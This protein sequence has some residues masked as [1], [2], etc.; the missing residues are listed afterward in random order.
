MQASSGEAKLSSEGL[1]AAQTP[2]GGRGLP[3]EQLWGWMAQ[4]TGASAP[5]PACS[6]S[7]T[8]PSASLACVRIGALAVASMDQTGGQRPARGHTL[9]TPDPRPPGA[10]GE[11]ALAQTSA[12]LSHTPW[13]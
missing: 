8:P 2:G 1:M 5:G 10:G 9:G 13:G 7:R 12:L 6:G 4:S 3:E 11:A